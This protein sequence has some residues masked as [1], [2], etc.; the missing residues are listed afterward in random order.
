MTDSTRLIEL[1]DALEKRIHALETEVLTSK[2]RN[3]TDQKFIAE[4]RSYV[5]RFYYTVTISLGAIIL[6]I[7][8]AVIEK[9]GIGL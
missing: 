6:W 2:I 7:A 4:V 1:V 3:E 9:A 5:K 8:K